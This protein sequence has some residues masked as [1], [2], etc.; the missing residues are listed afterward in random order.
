MPGAAPGAGGVTRSRQEQRRQ[1]PPSRRASTGERPVLAAGDDEPRP[2]RGGAPLL[3][4][5]RTFPIGRQQRAGSHGCIPLQ[6]LQLRQLGIAAEDVQA[7]AVQVPQRQGGVFCGEPWDS[8][9]RHC[10]R[11]SRALGSQQPRRA[12]QQHP[13][14][15]DA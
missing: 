12:H 15:S 11:C 1:R 8:A 9:R 6:V 3:C 14:A 2:K 5:L 13:P 10:V 7:E 4:V